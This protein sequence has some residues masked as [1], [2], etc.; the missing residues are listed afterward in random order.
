[1]TPYKTKSYKLKE[2]TRKTK[3]GKLEE[4]TRKMKE[5]TQKMKEWKT[6]PYLLSEKDIA[7][8]I[9]PPPTTMR[10]DP[11]SAPWYGAT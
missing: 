7:Y 8:G 10:E 9:L 2:W 4:W 11:I 6:M 3:E 5:W 1:M